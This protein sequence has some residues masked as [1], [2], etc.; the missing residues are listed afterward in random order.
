MQRDNF[1]CNT[2]WYFEQEHIV[3]HWDKKSMYHQHTVV[4]LVFEPKIV[5]LNID[6]STL[7]IDL[8]FSNAGDIKL[9][10]INDIPNH[11]SFRTSYFSNICIPLIEGI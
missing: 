11:M 6:H 1:P 5:F 4:Q 3:Y 8:S 2:I 9:L 7:N 10:T